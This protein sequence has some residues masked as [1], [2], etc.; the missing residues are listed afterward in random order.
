[1][2]IRQL[3]NP[4]SA[5]VI[6]SKM[7][8]PN[9]QT[10]TSPESI[11]NLLNRHFV[12]A[13]L[14]VDPAAP[15]PTIS[16]LP[17]PATTLHSLIITSSTVH[18]YI[19]R[20]PLNK[21]P[22]A[23]RITNEILR[24][25]SYSIARP[26]SILFNLSLSSGTFPSRW[27]SATVILVYK[28]EGD[29]NNPSNY[30]PISLLSCVSKLLERIV[31][32]RLYD[33]ISPLLH[34]AQS[35]FRRKDNTSLQLSRIIQD[36]CSLKDQRQASCICF[37]DLS[38]AFDTVWHKGLI[39]KLRAHGVSGS[40]LAW[41]TSYLLDRNQ[42]VTVN[43]TLSDPESVTSGVPQ[44]SISGPLLFLTY[45]NDL[46]Y[47]IPNISLLA[48]D[49]TVFASSPSHATLYP[50][51]QTC[52][53]DIVHWMS[54]WYLKP[55]VTKTEL[56]LIPPPTDPVPIFH[57]PDDP[58][59]PISV[60]PHHK[61]LG[62]VIDSALSWS[63]HADHVSSK[64]CRS[65]G[66]MSSHLSHLPQNCRINFHK[67][68]IL[69]LFTYGFPAWST[70]NKTHI[71][72][73]EVLHRRIL[74]IIF[75]TDRYITNLDLYA[76]ASTT[77]LQ[78][79]LDASKCTLAHS[80]FLDQHPAHL[81]SL[82]WFNSGGTTRSCVRLPLAMSTL[83]VNSPFFSSY[84]TW[85]QLPPSVRQAPD[86]PKFRTLVRQHFSISQFSLLPWLVSP[87]PQFNWLS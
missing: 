51:V 84:S 62:I 8:G 49:T 85:L 80:I 48:D 25:L 47:S 65:A 64:V 15:I 71:G 21:S 5:R 27:K 33:H 41:I 59:H 31:F 20:L 4:T 54:T 14:Q 45:V 44:G 55:N 13:G 70:I 87:S 30:R 77:T 6:P 66:I 73:L 10:S 42:C 24:K 56:L 32:D 11:G 74:R 75:R 76:A 86:M 37:L 72:K 19:A 16:S 61:H 38:K 23:D 40:L 34:P 36:L 26:F 53:N 57:F 69:P 17:P 60:A 52:I 35:G 2:L 78:H 29:K 7:V 83:F 18:K 50:K 81:Q 3:R 67:S 63:H 9:G 12:S 46:P 39:A 82:N 22:G 28:N 68:C 58:G 1:M 43:G 79:Y